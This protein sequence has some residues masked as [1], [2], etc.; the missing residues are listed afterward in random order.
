MKTKKFLLYL[1]LTLVLASVGAYAQDGAR[2][3]NAPKI[4]WYEGQVKRQA[5]VATDEFAVFAK[6]GERL[7]EAAAKTVVGDAEVLSQNAAMMLLRAK[8]NLSRTDGATRMASLRNLPGASGASPVAYFSN[9]GDEASRIVPLAEVVVKFNAG[10]GEADLVALAGQVT[11]LRTFDFSPNTYLYAVADAQTALDAANALVEA[12]KVE[13]AHPNMLRSMTTRATPDDTYFASHQWHLNNTGQFSGTAG[14]DV[15][16]TSVWDTYKGSTSEVIAIVDDG[17]DISHEDLVDNVVSGQH[18]DYVDADTDPTAGSHG[19]AC[20]GVAAAR[21]F[22]AQGVTGA[23]PEAN[24]IGHRLLGNSTDSNSADAL[25]RNKSIIDIYSNSWGPSDDG[26]N[27]SPVGTLVGPALVDGV[28]NGRGGLGCIYTWAGGNGKTDGDNSNYDGKANSRYT[29]AVAAST[30]YGDQSSYSEDGAN[31]FVNSPSNGGSAGI[32]TTDGTGSAGYVSGEY[33]SGFGGTSS[34]TPLV[35]GIIALMLEANANLTWRDVQHIV[36]TTAEKNDPTDSSWTTNGAGHDISHKY[37]FGRIDA[38]A[39]VTAALGWS[40]VP[41][42]TTATT[43]ASNPGSAI[44]DNNSTGVSDTI[45]VTD[46]LIIEYVDITFSASDHARWGDLKIVL[47]S[48]DG[49]ESILAE[50]HDSGVTAYK[51]DSWRFGS[52]MHFGETSAGNWTLTVKDLA[53]SYTGTF[54]SWSLKFYGYT[55]GAEMNVTGN[56][57]TIVDGDSEPSTSDH[58]DFG[59]VTVSS[60]TQDRTFTIQNTGSA[61]LTLSGSPKVAVGG[62]HAA[63]FTVTSQPSSPVAASGSTTFTVQ[64]DPSASGTRT[65]TL[66]IANDDSDENPYN[67]SIQGTGNS[68]PVADVSSS[69]TSG[70][71]G[72]SV[73]LSGSGSYDPDDAPTTP[74]SYS[75]SLVSGPE[76]PTLSPDS[77]SQDVTFTPGTA[78][79]Y[80]YRLTVSDGAATD[81]GD[82]TVVVGAAIPIMNVKGNDTSISSGDTTPSTSDHT[83]FSTAQLS[84]TTVARTFTIENNGSATLNLSG[85]PRIAISGTHSADFAVTTNAAATV[86]ASSTTTFVIT[87]T[88]GALGTRTASVSI[89]NDSSTNPYTFSIQGTGVN[90][91]EISVSGN[92]TA[93]ASGDT[94]PSEDDHTIFADT[95]YIVGTSSR[96][97]TISNTGTGDLAV[98]GV[99][100]SGTH[101]SDFSV[102]T[103]PSSTVAGGSTTTFV[104]TFDP[105]ESGT[106]SATVTIA[107]NDSDESSYTFSIEGDGVFVPSS[108]S[109][110]GCGVV[111]GDSLPFSWSGAILAVLALCIF[112]RRRAVTHR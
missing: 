98:T 37:G 3:R 76:T 70:N 107:N 9:G 7:D 97:Y 49:T 104:V 30:N 43:S 47:T 67:F 108:S 42:E 81:T 13:F 86:A 17:M 99:M 38:Q 44:P 52:V 71:V 72:L 105:S 45:N 11:L 89:T 26:Q 51:Y 29:I 27:L 6:K 111:F 112:F 110:G 84:T 102:T 83:D 63:D 1:S 48:P 34:A 10:A 95:N 103:S 79:T 41:S 31:I 24:L 55:S 32:T 61:T 87:F 77:T 12:G 93:I 68:A 40:N 58:T 20:S 59:T 14:E 92:S 73:S 53:S 54:E 66:S 82:V 90:P 85:S 5:Y 75:W 35:S 96:T 15:N 88:P 23:A 109:D 74:I 91:P 101:S 19:T 80:V 33:V 39:A 64:F 36:L 50:Q 60:G 65:A 16:I 2:L 57:T 69:E 28:T 46:N 78:G 8:N 106:R 100:I 56:S 4:Y 18:Y 21:G 62:T 25:T 22:N 94:T